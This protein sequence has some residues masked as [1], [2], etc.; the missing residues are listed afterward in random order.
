MSFFGPHV[1]QDGFSFSALR[2]AKFPIP[3]EHTSSFK[4]ILFHCSICSWEFLSGSL[5]RRMFIYCTH[6]LSD[7]F[8]YVLPFCMLFVTSWLES[9]TVLVLVVQIHV[10]R[11]FVLTLTSV[12]LF[13]SCFEVRISGW[14]Q[15]PATIPSSSCEES[16]IPHDNCTLSAACS[17]PAWSIWNTFCLRCLAQALFYPKN[18][19]Q[20]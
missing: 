16:T 3:Q 14:Q 2:V 12:Q 11:E 10:S 20:Y 18:Q 6:L 19:I 8:H 9:P 4:V 1:F 17:S 15:F 13:Q 7:S 5:I